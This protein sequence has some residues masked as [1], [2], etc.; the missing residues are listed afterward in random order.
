M[1]LENVVVSNQVTVVKTDALGY[2][3]FDTL[4]QMG[5]VSI[6]L[7]IGC[8]GD[9]WQKVTDAQTRFDFPLVETPTKTNFTFIHASDTH[10]QLTM[11]IYG[12]MAILMN[13]N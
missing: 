8:K 5:T 12:I 10:I 4:L 13:G 7:P 1:G 2:Y 6:S 9:F 3:Q 11:M